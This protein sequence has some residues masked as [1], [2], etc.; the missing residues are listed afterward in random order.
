MPSF[1]GDN[2]SEDLGKKA[3][4]KIREWLNRPEEGYCLDR[5]VDQMSGFYGG[6][7]IC[8]FTLFKSPNFYYIESKATYHDRFDFSMLTEYQ[9][10]NMLAKSSI[11]SVYCWVI[12][13]Y[14]S[15]QRAFI[16]DIRDIKKLEDEGTKSLNIKKID[17]W[18][19]R[20]TEIQTIRNSRKQ[21]LDYTGE[22]ENYI[23]SLMNTESDISK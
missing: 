1:K 5:V 11:Q 16:F 12:V 3:E 10:D 23:E 18:G 19:I 4:R 14:A 20:Y 9:H 22:I 17:K 15:Y 2:M 21:L 13:L 8:D 6:R 7:N